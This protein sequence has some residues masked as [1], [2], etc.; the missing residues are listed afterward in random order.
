MCRKNP[1]FLYINFFL[2]FGDFFSELF[3][4][5][6]KPRPITPWE[7]IQDFD[8]DGRGKEFHKCP[9]VLGYEN[10]VSSQWPANTRINLPSRCC[11]LAVFIQWCLIW[12]L[13][14]QWESTWMN[15]CNLLKQTLQAAPCFTRVRRDKRLHHGCL[16]LREVT[17]KIQPDSRLCLPC[18]ADVRLAKGL[19]IKGFSIKTTYHLHINECRLWGNLPPIHKKGGPLCPL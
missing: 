3:I 11:N 10:Q 18:T 15:P 16:F 7:V 4:F 8:I 19:A 5:L 14:Q 1:F 2:I 6:I 13:Y 17:G 12:S 9:S